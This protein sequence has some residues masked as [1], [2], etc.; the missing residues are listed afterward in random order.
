ME[1]LSSEAA[2]MAGHWGLD[3]LVWLYDD[4]KITIDGST[5][6]AFSEDVATRFIGLGWNVT[7]VGDANGRDFLPG[8]NRVIFGRVVPIDGKPQLGIEGYQLW[9]PC[10]QLPPQVRNRRFLGKLESDR[11][12][13]RQLTCSGKQ[14]DLNADHR[15]GDREVVTQEVEGVLSFG[16]QAVGPGQ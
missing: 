7:R 1:G 9:I 4:N 13:A 11:R 8:A 16:R 6:L 15:L 10:E 12:V 2:S 14:F 5:D 3:N